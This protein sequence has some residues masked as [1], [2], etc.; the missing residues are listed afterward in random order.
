MHGE[1]HSTEVTRDDGGQMLPEGGDRKILL[2]LEE[3]KRVS[4]AGAAMTESEG[5]LSAGGANSVTSHGGC[6]WGSAPGRR[7][8]KQV[9][10]NMVGGH[11]K[12]LCA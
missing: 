3:R 5:G 2:T 9:S 10:K 1:V 6:C 11:G 4:R 12:R 7:C 8:A